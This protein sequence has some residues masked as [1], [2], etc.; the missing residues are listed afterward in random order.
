MFLTGLISWWYSNGWLN[1]VRIIKDRIAASA[2]FFSVELLAS[3]LFAPFRQIS[4][5]RIT[6]GS[7]KFKLQN[8]FDRTLSRV[9]GAIVRTIVIIIGLLTITV[10]AIFGLVVLIIWLLAP[11][12]PVAGLT[13][14]TIGWLPW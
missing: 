10:Q 14:M 4:A 1:R 13:L 6:S 7:I 2:D 3:T 5:T 9:I 11:L 8:L 12:L